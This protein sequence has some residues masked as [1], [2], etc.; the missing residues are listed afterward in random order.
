[1]KNTELTL[2]KNAGVKGVTVNSIEYSI[3]FF[4]KAFKAFTHSK[5]IS[6]N[7]RLRVNTLKKAFTYFLHFHPARV[8]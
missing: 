2:S 3:E 5:K 1:L 4:L 7:Q 6:Y 8:Q